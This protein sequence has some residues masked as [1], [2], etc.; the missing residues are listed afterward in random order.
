MNLKMFML[1]KSITII[2]WYV[3]ILACWFCHTLLKP[4]SK[5]LT[6]SSC[7]CERFVV[8]L[9]IKYIGR[10]ETVCLLNVILLVG[11]ISELYTKFNQRHRLCLAPWHVTELDNNDSKPDQ[12]I[13]VNFPSRFHD[14]HPK[15]GESMPS[16]IVRNSTTYQPSHPSIPQ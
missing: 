2:N 5:I 16:I 8:F 15:F 9:L 6:T 14:T 1:T 7:I 13:S 10:C 12:Q 11:D 4:H 3:F